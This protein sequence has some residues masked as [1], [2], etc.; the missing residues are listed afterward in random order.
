MEYTHIHNSGQSCCLVRA[1]GKDR[2]YVVMG[3]NFEKYEYYQNSGFNRNVF[4][5]LVYNASLLPY[6]KTLAQ[7]LG[8]ML[9]NAIALESQAK[10]IRKEI[11][12]IFDRVEG[13]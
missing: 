1:F 13:K 6:D 9:D 11:H 7:Q 8:A 4:E 5:T 3:D 2:T 12:G 10:H